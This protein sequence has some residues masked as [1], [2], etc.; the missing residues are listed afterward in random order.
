MDVARITFLRGNLGIYKR[1]FT[2]EQKLDLL[3]C[4]LGFELS[5]LLFAHVHFI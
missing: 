3:G 2:C 5:G 1:D 4:I